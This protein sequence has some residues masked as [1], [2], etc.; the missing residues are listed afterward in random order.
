MANVWLVAREMLNFGGSLYVSVAET[1]SA[2]PDQKSPTLVL[3]EFPDFRR[4]PP[5]RFIKNAVDCEPV[6]YL[7]HGNGTCLALSKNFEGK[8]S[9]R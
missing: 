1:C 8:E 7:S 2:I 6:R 5:D 4:F 9:Y 3:N